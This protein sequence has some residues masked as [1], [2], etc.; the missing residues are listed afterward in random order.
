MYAFIILSLVGCSNTNP[1]QLD[2]DRRYAVTES[3]DTDAPLVVTGITEDGQDFLVDIKSLETSGLPV[4]TFQCIDPW[5]NRKI[6]YTG[7][8][9]FQ[10]L[11]I[12]GMD[13]N[14]MKVVLTADN[15]YQIVVP[16]DDIK[17]YYYQ[18]TFKEDGKYY[19]NLPD[20]QNKGTFAISIDFETFSDLDVTRYKLD[21]VWWLRE[22][23]L[24]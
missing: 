2:I 14:T 19:R 8:S 5:L 23:E 24:R 7:V 6:E 9:L 10:L 4:Y 11:S 3:S 15:D 16:I 12:I 17:N 21:E 13:G 1:Y 18:L 22:I 20:E